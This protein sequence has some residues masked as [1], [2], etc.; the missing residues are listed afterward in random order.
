MAYNLDLRKIAEEVEWVKKNNLVKSSQITKYSFFFFNDAYDF[1]F[2]ATKGK[3]KS[4]MF[5]M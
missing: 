3:L 4:E 5:S 2:M 1:L